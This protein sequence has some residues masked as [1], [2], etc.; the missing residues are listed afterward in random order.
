MSVTLTKETTELAAKFFQAKLSFEVGPIGLNNHIQNKEP[1]QIIDLRTPEL[2]AKG[3][4]PGALNISYDELESK[5]PTLSKDR[6]TI[7][8]CYDIVCNLSTKAALLLAEKGYR[9][10]EL[11]GGFNE[12]VSHNL[13]TEGKAEASSCS[14]SKHS[15]G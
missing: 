15:C 4:V 8:Y 5:L 14:T 13:H 9:V 1:V 2:F 11:V 10:Q 3:H 12:W 6:T 7:V